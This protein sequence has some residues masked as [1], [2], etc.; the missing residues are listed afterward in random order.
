MAFLIEH[1][2]I[3]NHLKLIAGKHSFDIPYTAHGMQ[4]LYSI[5][6]NQS[7]GGPP[8]IGSVGL[9]TKAQVREMLEAAAHAHNEKILRSIKP[10]KGL[11]L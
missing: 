5:M 11:D 2:T 7:I 6:I 8:K 1:N 3:T 4:V 10:P 9:P